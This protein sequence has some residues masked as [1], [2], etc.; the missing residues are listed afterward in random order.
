MAEKRVLG[1]RKEEGSSDKYT[2]P[3]KKAQFEPIESNDVI[4]DLIRWAV[5]VKYEDLPAEVVEGVKFLILDAFGNTIAGS[6][7]GGIDGFVKVARMS[8]CPPQASIL[9][10]GGKTGATMAAFATGPQMRALD[11]GETNQEDPHTTE[12]LLPSLLAMAE[13]KKASG[14]E[15]IL[16][17]AV[18]AEVGNRLGGTITNTPIQIGVRGRARLS[19]PL[20]AVAAVC[21]LLEFDVPTTWHALGI[22]FGQGVPTIQNVKDGA[23]F[24]SSHGF[25]GADAILSALLAERGV[26]GTINI[27][28]GQWGYFKAFENV[29][30]LSRFTTD[31]GKDWRFHRTFFKLYPVCTDIQS[32]ISASLICVTKNNIKPEDVELVD[33]GAGQNQMEFVVEPREEKWHPQTPAACR[34]SMPYGIATAIVKRSVGPKEFAEEEIWDPRIRELMKKIT[35]NLDPEINGIGSRQRGCRITIKMK[36]GKKYEEKLYHRLGG[37]NVPEGSL[38]WEELVEKFKSCLP[39]SAKPFKEGNVKKLIKLIHNLDR[40]DDVTPIFELMTP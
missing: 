30:N 11:F 25:I 13:W 2:P 1:N 29:H 14:K 9:V 39:M 10:H 40:V 18:A 7:V 31:L 33:V 26:K 17:F 16:A 34:F 12:F 28:Q 32:S 5:S 23:H 20:S 21:K 4:G 3:A 6:N 35:I 24:Y 19:F 15:L 36:D 37:L 27:L 8:G 38:S 22:M